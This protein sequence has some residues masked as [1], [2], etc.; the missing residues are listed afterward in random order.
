MG[1][2]EKHP[3]QELKGLN[4]LI[5]EELQEKALM[6]I[7]EALMQCTD[8]LQGVVDARGRLVEVFTFNKTGL[9]EEESFMDTPF[10]QKGLVVF[11]RSPEG[12]VREDR[13]LFLE[14][15]PA[16][17]LVGVL[18]E[19]FFHFYLLLPEIQEGQVD[20]RELGPLTSL[21]VD[22][23]FLFTRA[24]DLA[25][26]LEEA[27]QGQ[28]ERVMAVGVSGKHETSDLT[29][30]ASLVE[31]AGGEVIASL[32]QQRNVPDPRFYLGWGKVETVRQ[33]AHGQGVDL[34]VFDVE[35]S[36]AQQRN[37]QERIGIRVIDRNQLILDI[38]ARHAHTREG[39]IQVEL[40]QLTYLLPRLT[41]KGT[42]LSRLGGGIGTRGPGE[43]KLEVDRRRIRTRIADLKKEMDQVRKQR[44]LQQSHRDI[45]IIALVGYT[46]AGKSTLLNSLTG[47]LVKTA[48]QLFATLDP[49]IRR[50]RLPDGRQVLITDTV[51]FIKKIPH[52]LVASFRATLEGVEQADLLMHVVDSSHPRW[53]EQMETVLDVLAEL[54]VL[55]KPRLTVFN[56]MDAHPV[57]DELNPIVERY[58][59]AVAVSAAQ[60]KNLHLL[61]HT[62]GLLIDEEMEVQ[63][64]FIPYDKG[65]FLDFFHHHSQVLQEDYG[66]EGIKI[67][68]RIKRDLLD[69]VRDQLSFL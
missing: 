43:T 9:P 56:K 28:K 46:N 55:H 54:D 18:K 41:G 49:T 51:G 69:Q 63:E 42:E 39:Q 11:R 30:L 67:R 57:P 15:R 52:T 37:L 60:K 10:N 47:S 16:W 24:R 21:E 68:V 50:C 26:N 61:L 25:S 23:Q 29:E 5:R 38:F 62:A 65:H 27:W 12:L 45:P 44:K 2:N 36:P 4:I 53:Q 35:L 8:P 14:L 19:G 64:L 17:L 1:N 58:G 22:E 31:T 13:E 48:D 34:I 32:E 7:E 3:L 40:A 6:T 20:S 33:E 59:P 66:Q